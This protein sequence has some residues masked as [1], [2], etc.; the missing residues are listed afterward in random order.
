MS[1]ALA[2]GMGDS[3]TGTRRR[4]GEGQKEDNCDGV[5]S[6]VGRLNSPGDTDG[7]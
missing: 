4:Y 2:A 6:G 3:L 5:R 7:T 1:R